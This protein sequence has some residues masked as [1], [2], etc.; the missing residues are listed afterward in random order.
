MM[1][2]IGWLST[3]LFGALLL[4]SNTAS[5]MPAPQQATSST[6]WPAYGGGPDSIRYSPLT[7]ID[8]SNVSQ[9]Q[10]A[11]T[12]DCEEGPGSTQT[13]PLVVGGVLYAVTPQHKIVALDA[14]TGKP[15]L[16][17]RFWHCRAWPQSR[18]LVLDGGQ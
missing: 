14:A 4:A 12:Y 15:A 8:R 2:R 11:W 9:L 1:K 7:Q 18:R 13:Q 5:K 16:E 17:I 10:V 6:E 3:A